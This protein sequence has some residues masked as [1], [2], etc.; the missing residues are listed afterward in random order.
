VK[1]LMSRLARLPAIGLVAALLFVLLGDG[2]TVAAAEDAVRELTV[3]SGDGP[4]AIKLFSAVGENRHPAVIILPGR[5]DFD[6][7]AYTRF[8]EGLA[9][10]GIDAVLVS[11]YDAADAA[12]MGTE[13]RASRG[14]YFGEHLPVRSERV[15]TVTGY[16]LPRSVASG[17]VG[18]LG[19][20]NC[21]FLAV[22]AA[23]LDPRVS[24]LVVFYGGIAGKLDVTRLPLVLALHGDADRIIPLASGTKLVEKAHALGGQAELVVYAGAG[25]GFDH[26]ATRT[27]TSDSLARTLAF[28]ASQLKP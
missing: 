11:Y 2:A 5:Q 4:I 1:M 14:R 12:A 18:L 19:F 27:E 3:E 16:L 25:H 24:A 13:D 8:A 20:S 21:G 26:D 17:K 9:A 22:E 15:Q 10:K 28:F 7:N 6:S 23:V